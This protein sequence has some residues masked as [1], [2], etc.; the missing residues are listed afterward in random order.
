MINLKAN[1]SK[2][3]RAQIEEF[4]WNVGMYIV[5]VYGLFDD[6]EYTC[7]YLNTCDDILTVVGAE[8]IDI[9]VIDNDVCFEDIT[10]YSSLTL[11][12]DHNYDWEF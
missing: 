9:K 7:C 11:L 1:E 2:E 8:D 5:R 10:K 12:V 3:F 6:E 4:N